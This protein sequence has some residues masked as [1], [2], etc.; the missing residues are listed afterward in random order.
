MSSLTYTCRKL[1]V[2]SLWSDPSLAWWTV[3]TVS[4]SKREHKSC[5]HPCDPPITSSK[6]LFLLCISNSWIN[7]AFIFKKFT[8]FFKAKKYFLCNKLLFWQ[9]FFSSFFKSIC[10]LTDMGEAAGTVPARSTTTDATSDTF[11]SEFELILP[12]FANILKVLQEGGEERQIIKLVN[13]PSYTHLF[14]FTFNNKV[15]SHFIN[16]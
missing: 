15:L 1:L 5:L 11:L 14:F 6:S 2:A 3:W 8:F 13:A 10:L 12:K 4:S 9:K 16:Y 7:Q